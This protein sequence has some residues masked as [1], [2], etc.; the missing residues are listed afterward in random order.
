MAAMPEAWQDCDNQ[1]ESDRGSSAQHDILGKICHVQR[2]VKERPYLTIPRHQSGLL[3]PWR[4]G[5]MQLDLA[6]APS[7]TKSWK[8]T[9]KHPEGSSVVLICGI[10]HDTRP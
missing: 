10:L 6:F 9:C 7:P 2:G 4:R 1:T 5:Y 8:R 3:L